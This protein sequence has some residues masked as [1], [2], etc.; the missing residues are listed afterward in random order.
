MSVGC[1]QGGTLPNRVSQREA[2]RALL[3]PALADATALVDLVE[4]LFVARVEELEVAVHG[5]GLEL[6][7]DQRLRAGL[8]R[9]RDL[10]V[11]LGPAVLEQ[12]GRTGAPERLEHELAEGLVFALVEE[13][14]E[15]RRHV[16]RDPAS[17]HGQAGDPLTLE[18]EVGV[19]LRRVLVVPIEPRLE[20]DAPVIVD[21][22][23]EVESDPLSELDTVELQGIRR[24]LATPIGEVV[25]GD[26][27]VGFLSA[28]SL[29]L[30]APMALIEA[31]GSFRS[32]VL[33]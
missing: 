24:H 29:G 25:A 21:H 30:L 7:A 18:V 26:D 8:E 28:H 19:T 14:D 22:D 4:E 13:L 1:P 3:V 27:L 16:D 12:N 23:D 9:Y 15:Q 6:G 31:V 10:A 11:H 17:Q 5:I 2:L 20:P 33:Y 32:I